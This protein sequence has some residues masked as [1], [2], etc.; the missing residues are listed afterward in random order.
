MN[1]YAIPL[2]YKQCTPELE[3]EIKVL[4]EKYINIGDTAF[5][6]SVVVKNMELSAAADHYTRQERNELR[7]NLSL[8]DSS[9]GATYSF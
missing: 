1:R 4:K 8:M 3:S 2:L 6:Q 7:E 9:D 5:D